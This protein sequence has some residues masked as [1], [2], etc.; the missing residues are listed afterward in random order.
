MFAAGGPGYRDSRD[1]AHHLQRLPAPGPG[2]GVHG[3]VWAADQSEIQLQ[4]GYQ[5]RHQER[6]LHGSLQVGGLSEGS[7]GHWA[8]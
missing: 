4:P 5:R 2:P 6:V 1:P 3:A 8:V 7:V